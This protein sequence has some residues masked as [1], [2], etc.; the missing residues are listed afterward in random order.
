MVITRKLFKE[1][2]WL[3][4]KVSWLDRVNGIKGAWTNSGKLPWAGSAIQS[5]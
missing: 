3:D 2:V 4:P 1:E 5:L